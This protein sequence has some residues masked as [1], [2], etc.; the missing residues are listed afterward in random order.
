M[1]SEKFCLRWNDFESNISSAFKDIRDEKEFFDITIACEDEQLQAHKVILSACSPFFKN[2][3]RRNQ[4]QHPLLYLKGVS[5]RDMESVLNFMY[6]GE[7]NVAQDDLNSFLQVAEDLRV[8]GLT[9]TNSGNVAS[10]PKNHTAV[11]KTEPRS[12]LNRPR[13]SE[14][15]ISPAVKRPRPTPPAPR[16]NPQPVTRQED[17]IEVIVPVVKS[18]PHDPTPSIMATPI[19][20]VVQPVVQQQ[21]LAMYDDGS[22]QMQGSMMEQ[23]D[24][25]YG[26]EYDGQFVDDQGYDTSMMGAGGQDASGAGRNNWCNLCSKTVVNYNRHIKD[27][28]GTNNEVQCE[29]CNKLFKNDASCKK[30]MRVYHNIYLKSDNLFV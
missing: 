5:F 18:E 13:P 15:D 17:D 27:V 22:Q 4:H 21:T 9:Q 8:K 7:V 26:G 10:E 28:H 3:L 24:D 12:D 30:H 16:I 11:P 23:Y 20:P 29:V 2:V 25:N 6:H 1:S 19:Q 14:H